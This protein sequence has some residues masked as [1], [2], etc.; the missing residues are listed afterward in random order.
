[1]IGLAGR[2]SP[3][4]WVSLNAKVSGLPAGGYGYIVDAEGSLDINPIKYVGISA[5][6]RYL[7]ARADYNDNHADYQ[8]DGPFAG[9][10]IR[11]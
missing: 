6:Y 3:I 5:G 8:L 11:F 2:I 4:P 7:K 10:H 1:M 9:L